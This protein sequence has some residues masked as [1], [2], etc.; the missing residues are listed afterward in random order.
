MTATEFR[1][2]MQRMGYTQ[3]QAASALG[4]S[5]GWVNSAATGRRPMKRYVELACCYLERKAGGKPPLPLRAPPPPWA[6]ND[7]AAV[8]ARLAAAEAKLEDINSQMDD[9][10]RIAGILLKRIPTKGQI[11]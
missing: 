10:W 8:E 4:R 3:A 7:M 9:L 1:E 2:W 5:V 11:G 6:M